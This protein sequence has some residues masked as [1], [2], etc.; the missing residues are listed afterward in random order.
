MSAIRKETVDGSASI[1]SAAQITI[2]D[3]IFVAAISGMD[4]GDTKVI[5][6]ISATCSRAPLA[7][8]AALHCMLE[9]LPLIAQ[10]PRCMVQ[11]ISLI[12]TALKCMVDGLALI[13]PALKC[14]VEGSPR[15]AAALVSVLEHQ[16]AT[17][18]AAT[19]TLKGA[20]RIVVRPARAHTCATARERELDGGFDVGTWLVD[21][22][23]VLARAWMRRFRRSG[24]WP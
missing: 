11:D 21:G 17:V 18:N 6:T 8:G 20:A 4:A 13:S 7:L 5:V 15:I 22:C 16:P 2:E 9:H 3:Y 14:M 12:S 23:N 24:C 1:V 19:S 10:A